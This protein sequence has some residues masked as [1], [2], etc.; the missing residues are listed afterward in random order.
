MHQPDLLESVVRRARSHLELD[1]LEEICPY[2]SRIGY[3]FLDSSLVELPEEVEVEVGDSHSHL[4]CV[5][6]LLYL[7]IV[8][9]DHVHVWS[10]E[11][12]GGN[13][14]SL[15]NSIYLREMCHEMPK[16]ELNSAVKLCRGG[17]Q[18]E[19]AH[20]CIGHAVYLLDCKRKTLQKVYDMG[21]KNVRLI[22]LV[23]FLMVWPPVFPLIN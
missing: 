10:R 19:L 16:E 23:S 3:F 13:I 9:G 20:L 22:R 14:W 11:M 12:D 5:D 15:M 2:V 18:A 8:K 21:S 1:I 17:M 4:S 6:D 7:I